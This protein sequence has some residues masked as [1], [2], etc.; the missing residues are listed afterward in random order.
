MW[1]KAEKDTKWTIDSPMPVKKWENYCLFDG[2]MNPDKNNNEGLKTDETVIKTKASVK[3]LK[4]D[5][6]R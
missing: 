4:L 5:S 1:A 6:T 3:S 2:I